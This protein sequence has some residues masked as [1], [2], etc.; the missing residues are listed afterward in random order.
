MKLTCAQYS[1]TFEIGSVIS[2]PDKSPNFLTSNDYSKTVGKSGGEGDEEG[3]NGQ[4]KLNRNDA[5]W[6]KEAIKEVTLGIILEDP[7]RGETDG[8]KYQAEDELHSGELE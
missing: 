4:L 5:G 7:G 2:F 8:R 3:S 1:F 6:V